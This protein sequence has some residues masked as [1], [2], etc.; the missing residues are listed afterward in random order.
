MATATNLQGHTATASCTLDVDFTALQLDVWAVPD[1]FAPNN[2]ALA[3]THFILSAQ[4]PANDALASWSLRV[5]DQSGQLVWSQA[6]VGALTDAGLIWDGRDLTGQLPSSSTTFSYHLSGVSE[7][8]VS[9]STTPQP[10]TL[11]IGAPAPPV[12]ST[13]SD[14]TTQG[15]GWSKVTG[16]IAE[17]DLAVVVHVQR[18]DSSTV[19]RYYDVTV[20]GLTWSL[21]AVALGSGT[22]QIWAT[23]F[24]P[25]QQESATSNTVNVT[26][27]ALPPLKTLAVSPAL[28]GLNDVLDVMATAR[29]VVTDQN[30]PDFGLGKTVLVEGTWPTLSGPETQSLSS[31]TQ[32][33]PISIWSMS[34]SVDSSLPSGVLN[35]S[36]WGE[37]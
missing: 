4:A 22:N 34:R 16:T 32:D 36:V 21:P 20:D 11:R 13:P 12:I 6:G 27:A 10:L 26:V 1:A 31:T 3:T 18:P 8:G 25:A 29:G 5:E 23:A 17:P 33:D 9:G 35:I 28:A 15:L 2:P 37:E 30:D 14:P 24:D 19:R 7:A